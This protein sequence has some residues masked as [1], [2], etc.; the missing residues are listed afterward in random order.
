VNGPADLPPA[1][2][3]PGLIAYRRTP[4]FSEDTVAAGLRRE[5]RTKPGVWAL[6]NVLDGRL[7]FRALAPRFERVLSAGGRIAV[8]PEQ[9]HEVDPDG[10]VRFF[11]EFYRAADP[12]GP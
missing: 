7:R 1:D 9:P 2:L 8:P 3:P 12:P 11:V 6:I 10:P 5:H 4:V